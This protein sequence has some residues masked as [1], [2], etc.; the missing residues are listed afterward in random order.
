MG[1]LVSFKF[2][3]HACLEGWG[4]GGFRAFHK[5]PEGFKATSHA[6]GMLQRASEA[7]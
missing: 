6:L 2:L 4:G 1:S 5:F 3:I 7:F